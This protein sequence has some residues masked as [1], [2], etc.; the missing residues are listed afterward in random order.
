MTSY[1]PYIRSRN[2]FGPFH[3]ICAVALIA[4]RIRHEFVQGRQ[5]QGLLLSLLV[6]TVLLFCMTCVVGS[7]SIQS[8]HNDHPGHHCQ[9]H[10]NTTSFDHPCLYPTASHAMD[11]QGI[12][13]TCFT[14]AEIRG[15]L[16]SSTSL[17]PR[18]H[19]AVEHSGYLRDAVCRKV[20]SIQVIRLQQ[21]PG[22]ENCRTLP[23]RTRAWVLAAISPCFS[24]T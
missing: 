10:H 6:R 21:E 5:N 19:P 14:S 18:T 22:V 12:M 20:Q 24:C 23:R 7:L 16:S 11:A 4:R 1:L 13:K 2:C 17:M 3:K 8:V 15:Y 9:H